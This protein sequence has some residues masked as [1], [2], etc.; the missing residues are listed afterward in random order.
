MFWQPAPARRGLYTA[1]SAPRKIPL[2]VV[3]VGLGRHALSAN[4]RVFCL[5]ITILPG[6]PFDVTLRI[7]SLRNQVGQLV[8]STRSKQRNRPTRESRMVVERLLA[9]LSLHLA[10][11]DAGLSLCALYLVR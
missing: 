3:K 11:R 7:V 10:G 6:M 4:N 9:P 1:L 8:Y 2:F 5:G